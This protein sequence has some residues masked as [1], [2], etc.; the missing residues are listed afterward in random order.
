[1]LLGIV[2]L[3]R[4]SSAETQAAGD[5]VCRPVLGA[6]V[7][8]TPVVKEPQEATAAE[9]DFDPSFRCQ[10]TPD[11]SQVYPGEL[12]EVSVSITGKPGPFTVQGF[13]GLL[14]GT[15]F[16]IRG[17]YNDP[18]VDRAMTREFRV[19][20]ANN[21]SKSAKCSFPITVKTR[22]ASGSSS[23][24]CTLTASPTVASPNTAVELK[25]TL[26]GATRPVDFAIWPAPHWRLDR[27]DSRLV[28]SN[29]VRA[30]VRFP[31]AGQR[32][33]YAYVSDGS[34][35]AICNTSLQ[36]YDPILTL[37]ASPSTTA[38]PSQTISVQATV[39]GFPTAPDLSFT[40]NEPG[41]TVGVSGTTATI[42]NTDG[43][44]H[45]FRL[46]VRAAKGGLE[47]TQ[48]IDLSYIPTTSGALGCQINATVRPFVG[49]DETFQLAVA[50]GSSSSSTLYRYSHQIP[51]DATLVEAGSSSLKLRFS[52]PG[53]KTIRMQAYGINPVNYCN[54][55]GWVQTQVLVVEH[56]ATRGCSVTIAPTTSK[57]LDS[58]AAQASILPNVG[59]GPFQL[60]SLEVEN[61]TP[62]VYDLG[63]EPVPGEPRPGNNPLALLVRFVRWN[64]GNVPSN[65]W[66]T[67]R[68]KVLDLG[69][70]SSQNQ[71]TCASTH[72]IRP[73]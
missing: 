38:Y 21:P 26:S 45:Q 71:A 39:A 50:P 23:L 66:A 65:T 18:G 1:M 13:P 72:T 11:R 37:A 20:D 46:T 48:T 28:S 4:C 68:A 49:D 42:R 7:V 30:S 3:V 25:L 35:S 19:Y 62:S 22:N 55:D 43:L 9:P 10:A 63:V 64:P 57:L 14:F 27:S 36:I 40:T 52:T 58:V 67:Y 73:Q 51:S 34:T 16:S 61:S 24:G 15:P 32:S 54:G 31:T 8:C 17:S 53:L 47:R 6:G 56:L 12:V 29:E 59:R 33:P 41:I 60:D 69:D 5:Q 44:P 70:S 2:T